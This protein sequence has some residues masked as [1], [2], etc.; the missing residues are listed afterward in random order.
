MESC[1]Y[2]LLVGPII[3]STMAAIGINPKLALAAAAAGGGAPVNP[4]QL[5]SLTRV[6]LSLGAGV[7]EELLFRLAMIPAL[8]VLFARLVGLPRVVSLA[9]AFIISSLLFSAAHHVIGGEPWAV[10]PFVYRFFCGMIFA[11]LFQFRGLG[12]AVYTHALYDIYVML[13]R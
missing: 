4:Q 5:G 11:A 13:L 1:V 7:H 10:A 12:V 9:L 8:S 2:A 6:A 3:V